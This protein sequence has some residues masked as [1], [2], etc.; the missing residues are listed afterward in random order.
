MPG[1]SPIPAGWHQRQDAAARAVEGPT[2]YHRQED[3]TVSITTT[4]IA[5]RIPGGVEI[6]TVTITRVSSPPPRPFLD[7]TGEDVHE[8]CR[9]LELRRAA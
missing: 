9:V 3:P 6:T 8:P 2:T 5:R 7:T 4:T 1:D